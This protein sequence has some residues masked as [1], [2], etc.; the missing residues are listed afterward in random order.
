[1]KKVK[2]VSNN[3]NKFRNGEKIL[4]IFIIVNLVLSILN[5]IF[6]NNESAIYCV[7]LVVIFI[8]FYIYLDIRSILSITYSIYDAI[9]KRELNNINNE[10]KSIMEMSDE[11]EREIS[12]AKEKRDK[13]REDL[14]KMESE[15]PEVP[16]KRRPGRPRKNSI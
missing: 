4:N 7:M 11:I 13:I 14:S 12:K 5:Y 3:E 1:M 15:T 16:K 9:V 2:K 6:N 8:L 10:L